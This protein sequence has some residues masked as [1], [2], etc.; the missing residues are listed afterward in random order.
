M[1]LFDQPGAD[2]GIVTGL[3]LGDSSNI[4]CGAKD[5][6]D[7]VVPRDRM[8]VG[9]SSSVSGSLRRQVRDLGGSGTGGT[10]GVHGGDALEPGPPRAI[11]EL[12]CCLDGRTRPIIVG[13]DTLE[14]WQDLHGRLCNVTGNLTQLVAGQ[15]EMACHT[16]TVTLQLRTFA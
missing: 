4:G 6:P 10:M 2:I 16:T 13:P 5:V 1:G 7:L 11:D 12:P 9:G 15:L 14:L 3:D 8:Q